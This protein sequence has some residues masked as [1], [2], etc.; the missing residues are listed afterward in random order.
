MAISD[1]IFFALPFTSLRTDATDSSYETLVAMDRERTRIHRL[2]L[3]VGEVVR[4]VVVVRSVAGD[5][6]SGLRLN[7]ERLRTEQT[8][9]P[10]A[11][12]GARP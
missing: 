7:P 3:V 4:S 9:R 11:L 1:G 8:L 10:L 5:W 6:A 12:A 2:L